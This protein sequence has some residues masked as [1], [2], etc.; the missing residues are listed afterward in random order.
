M[1]VRVG[2]GPFV[3]PPPGA[4]FEVHY[5]AGI[6]LQSNMDEYVEARMVVVIVIVERGDSVEDSLVRG[7]KL[8]PGQ[9]DGTGRRSGLLGRLWWIGLFLGG[10]RRPRRAD[11]G[12]LLRST[13]VEWGRFMREHLAIQGPSGQT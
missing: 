2:R 9:S 4:G 7:W 8:D 10:C 1:S 11:G 12:A 3:P 5:P 6:W 13:A